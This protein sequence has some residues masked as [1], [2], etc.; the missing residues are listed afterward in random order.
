MWRCE[1]KYR[2]VKVLGLMVGM[3]CGGNPS[4]AGDV[5]MNVTATVAPS[6]T[7]TV[8]T[9]MS[10]GSIDLNP[11]GDTIVINA[12]SGAATPASSGAASIVTGGASG[13]ITVASNNAFTINVVYEADS[14]VAL[15]E[16]ISG[17]I[18][19]LNS[20]DQYSEGGTVNGGVIHAAGID[21]LI[22]VGGSVQ[23]PAGADA[24]I[25]SG[26]MTITLNYL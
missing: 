19:Y 12:S 14:T 15:T 25:Y 2:Q 23:F 5:T 20:I 8:T 9:Q 16:P 26:S 21:S 11:G 17:S 6:L 10:F 7:E 13:L 22:N 4:W 1:N 18:V 24:G 3:L